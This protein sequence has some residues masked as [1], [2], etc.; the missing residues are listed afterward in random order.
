MQPLFRMA[1]VGK[2][3]D[4]LGDDMCSL[5]EGRMW[6]GGSRRLAQLRPSGLQP[7]QALQGESRVGRF[8]L[9]GSLTPSSM[10]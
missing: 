8:S 3:R 7:V 6:E 10:Q 5:N 9:L 1:N 2:Q 4:P